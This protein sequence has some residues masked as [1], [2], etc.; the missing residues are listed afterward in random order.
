MKLKNKVVM[1]TGAS[2]GIGKACAEKFAKKGAKLALAARRIEKLTE[3]RREEEMDCLC[4]RADVSKEEDVKRLFNETEQKYGKIDVLVNNAGKGLR[5]EMTEIDREEW[6]DLFGVNMTGVFMCSREAVKIMQRKAIKGQIITVSSMVGKIGAPKYSAY[7]ASK[8]AVTGFMKS[9]KMELFGKIK[10]NTIYPA[11]VQTEFF[12]DYPHD[13]KPKRWQMLNADDIADVIIAISERNWLKKII[14]RTR[15]LG[16]R[17][18][19]PVF[20]R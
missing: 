10:V 3:L 11:R 20:G 7:A 1:I 15:N 4:I 18:I 2:S 8:H 12:K 14:Y 6:D 19:A 5:K 17:I 9:I 13:K 16:K